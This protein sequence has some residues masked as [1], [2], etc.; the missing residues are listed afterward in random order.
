MSISSAQTR[1]NVDTLASYQM[2]RES[3]KSS[4][5]KFKLM[6]QSTA[7]RDFFSVL[8]ESVGI[9]I[10]DTEEEFNCYHRGTRIDF[11]EPLNES[12]VDYVLELTTKQVDSLVELVSVEEIDEERR[13]SIL[14]T[15][16]APAI[17]ASINPFPCL[18]GVTS[19]TPL[20]SNTLL[21]RLLRMENLIHV[22][23]ISPV[24]GESE[25]GH[26]LVFENKEWQ[27]STGLHGT[28]GRIFRL[29]ID[30][31]LEFHG[32]AYRA[33][34]ANTNMGWLKFGGWY[35]KWRKVVSKSSG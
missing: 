9:R 35:L 4:L 28:P 18:K 3:M 29:S 21:R 5:Q 15:L 23:I 2:N 26:T 27:V 14:K 19:S 33:L 22:Y 34:K 13:Y 6:Q 16:F 30:D 10:S 12:E 11:E 25:I 1:Y 17:E 20:V 7:T 8:F 32:Q 31:V 24:Q